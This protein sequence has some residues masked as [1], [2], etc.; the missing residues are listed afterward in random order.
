MK[1]IINKITNKVKEIRG[2]LKYKKLMKTNDGNTSKVFIDIGSSSIKANSGNAYI[3]FR[4]SVREV[5]NRNELTIQRNAIE[6][7]G[8]FFVIGEANT[9]VQNVT[10]KYTKENLNVL[11]LYAIKLLGEKVDINLD[12]IEVSTMSP[13]NQLYTKD[14]LAKVI[15]GNYVIK[16]L[17]GYNKEYNVTLANVQCEGETSLIYFTNVYGN[18]SDNTIVLGIGGSTID[19]VTIDNTLNAR[20]EVMTINQG[21][22]SLLPMYLKYLPSVPNSS[23]L[24]NFLK[25][26]KYKFT[27][28]EQLG[29]DLEN[30]LYLK[31]IWHDVESLI[32]KCNPY[33]TNIIITGGGA[34][35]LHKAI[36]ELLGDKYNLILANAKECLYS[37]LMGLRLIANDSN[38]FTP[39]EPVDSYQSENDQAEIETRAIPSGG[40]PKGKSNFEM[41]C[42]LKEQGYTLKQIHKAKLLP[43]TYNSLK[44]YSCRYNKLQL[45]S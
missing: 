23:L 34:M 19:C 30:R 41:F 33:S 38:D 25:S 5:T 35:L 44:N 40:E 14:K 16:D 3:N 28:E 12:N 31:A 6:V 32:R 26:G 11:V 39:V 15:N 37:D 18:K 8:K 42:A 4:A 45:S 43:L 27:K 9:E 7:N 13:F 24:G 10:L 2:K 1:R 22:S 29:I 20:Q 21:T 36:K 17:Q